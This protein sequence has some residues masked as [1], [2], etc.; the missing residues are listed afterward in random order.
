MGLPTSRET[1]TSA[2]E[3]SDNHVGIGPARNSTP[4]PAYCRD[5]YPAADRAELQ[6]DNT[7]SLSRG[8]NRAGRWT[9]T[10]SSGLD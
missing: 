2:S 10:D 1:T 6:S 9:A 3:K 4:C 7:D 5:M 8:E